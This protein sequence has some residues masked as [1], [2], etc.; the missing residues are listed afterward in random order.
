[1]VP[2]LEDQLSTLA[3]KMLD[4]EEAIKGLVAENKELRAK[5]EAAQQPVPLPSGTTTPPYVLSPYQGP[6]VNPLLGQPYP[7][8][9]YEQQRIKERLQRMEEE[10]QRQR[11]G[12][13]PLGGYFGGT[14][15][16]KYY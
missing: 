1:M 14:D 16:R 8:P 2:T 13:M 7:A 11:Q 3:L 9:N 5:I 6:L 10:Y 12:G 15:Y 4:M